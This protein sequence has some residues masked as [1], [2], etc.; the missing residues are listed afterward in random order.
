MRGIVTAVTLILTSA[1]GQ[2]QNIEM[3]FW[4]RRSCMRVLIGARPLQGGLQRIFAPNGARDE[5]PGRQA[6]MAGDGSGWEAQRAE[7]RTSAPV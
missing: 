4:S 5:G 3:C 6:W 2:S 7:L 1:A